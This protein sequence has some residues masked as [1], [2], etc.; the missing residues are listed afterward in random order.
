MWCLETIQAINQKAAELV[1]AGRS[2]SETYDELGIAGPTSVNRCVYT[3]YENVQGVF[4]IAERSD[5]QHQD[6]TELKIAK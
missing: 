1:M 4:G 6:A 5:V 2:Q 3:P